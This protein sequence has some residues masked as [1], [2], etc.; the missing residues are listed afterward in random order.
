MV[1]K[2]KE[3]AQETRELLLDAAEAVFDAKGVSRASLQDIASAAGLTRGAIYWHF[4]DKAD[5]FHAMMDRVCLPCEEAACALVEGA[6]AAD[7]RQALLGMALT[8]LE[9]M[10]HDERTRRVFTIAMLRVEMTDD[11]AVIR[12][13]R[14]AMVLEFVADMA[15]HL[16]RA[17]E[18]GSLRPGQDPRQAAFGL[19]ILVDGLMHNWALMPDAFDLACV[20]RQALEAYLHGVFLS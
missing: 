1:R 20:G 4:K 10:Q 19:F 6:P 3:E 13:R 12:E 18:A 16:C 14:R 7:I 8:V 17:H 11:L 15:Q 2:T 5:V 9:R